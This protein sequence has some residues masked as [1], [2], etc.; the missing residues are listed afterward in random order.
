MDLNLVQVQQP[1]IAPSSASSNVSL[2]SPHSF[3]LIST[4]L[5]RNKPEKHS[6]VSIFHPENS[7]RKVISQLTPGQLICFGIRKMHRVSKMQDVT[8]CL[9]G[10]ILALDIGFTVCL[11]VLLTYSLIQH[12][13]AQVSRLRSSYLAEFSPSV[14]PQINAS[15]VDAVVDNSTAIIPQTDPLGTTPYSWLFFLGFDL[16]FSFRLVILVM[17][18]SNVYTA[19][20]KFNQMLNK[21]LGMAQRVTDAEGSGSFCCGDE[22][23]EIMNEKNRKGNE[24][25]GRPLMTASEADTALAFLAVN[26][27]QPIAFSAGGL[28]TFS[29]S[30]IMLIVSVVISYL[31]FLFQT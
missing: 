4:K 21:V 24:K 6:S 30:T 8:N 31:V 1:K 16:C 28:L 7:K 10:P 13:G 2:K 27:S 19:S 20:M 11:V 17:C 9:F 23:L 15:S 25:E 3:P 14:N 26:S 12:M 29:N 22:D 5:E 18:L